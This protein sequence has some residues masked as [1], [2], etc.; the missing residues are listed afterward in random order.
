MELNVENYKVRKTSPI[1]LGNPG[2]PKNTERYVVSGMGVIGIDLYK[3]DELKIVNL[4]GSQIVE[5]V[6]FNNLGNCESI[7]G[8]D[9]NADANFIKEKIKS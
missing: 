1:I 4:E 9:Y 3:D 2:L 5:M 8:K 6:F 7:V